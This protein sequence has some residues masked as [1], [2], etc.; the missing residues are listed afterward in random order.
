MTV[1]KMTD[2]CRSVL[3]KVSKFEEMMINPKHWKVTKMYS[4][5]HKGLIR[6]ILLRTRNEDY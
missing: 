2:Y 1:T 3:I 6:A 5:V 4:Y